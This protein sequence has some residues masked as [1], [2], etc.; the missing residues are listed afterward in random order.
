MYGFIRTLSRFKRAMSRLREGML[1]HEQLRLRIDPE[2]LLNVIPVDIVADHAVRIDRAGADPGV[3][4]LTN[5]CLMHTRRAIELL[6]SVLDL[7]PPAF[8]GVA[9]G[10][11]WLD[12]QIDKGITFYKSYL[13]GVK[14]F[15]RTNVRG[16]LG[17]RV[18][19]RID[20]TPSWAVNRR[21]GAPAPAA[22][23]KRSGRRR[24]GSNTSG[25]S[26]GCRRV[27]AAACGS[28]DR[29]ARSD[30]FR[31][32]ARCSRTRASSTSS[33]MAATAPCR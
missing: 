2:S 16:V 29:A 13:F 6:F 28:S 1:D 31:G 19:C 3:F 30:R 20:G 23:W 25:C 21:P 4:H 12:Q 14:R 24:S 11:S 17:G 7:H 33:A 32:S 8:A 26:R 9:D 15:D 18:T 10:L 27:S 5:D 22:T